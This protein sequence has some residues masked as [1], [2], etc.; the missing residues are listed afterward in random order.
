[1]HL[2]IWHGPQTSDDTLQIALS[3]GAQKKKIMHPSWQL[4]TPP[5]SGA[6]SVWC[7]LTETV[8][9]VVT[10]TSEDRPAGGVESCH[11]GCMK[12]NDF[13]HPLTKYF[14][15]EMSSELCDPRQG[16]T[17]L[18]CTDITALGKKSEWS[19]FYFHQIE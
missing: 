4:S 12:A 13:R 9:G 19:L 8:V 15:V 3:D 18:T 1:M 7:V 5:A 6:V 11:S 2:C 17:S 14:E 10:E 16:S